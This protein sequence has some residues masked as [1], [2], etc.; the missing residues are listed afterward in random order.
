[1]TNPD[2]PKF[3]VAAEPACFEQCVCTHC[4]REQCEIACRLCVGQ[5]KPAPCTYCPDYI[6]REEGEA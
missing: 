5:K 2:E 3:H 4:Y 6:D 1:M